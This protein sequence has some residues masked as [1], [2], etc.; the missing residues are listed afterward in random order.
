[1]KKD[2]GEEAHFCR[3]CSTKVVRQI[4]LTIR[5]GIL[6]SFVGHYDGPSVKEQIK[7]ALFSLPFLGREIKKEKFL[8][9]SFLCVRGEDEKHTNNFTIF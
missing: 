2:L 8:R 6:P 5:L 3:P 9:F 1:M 7:N 4:T